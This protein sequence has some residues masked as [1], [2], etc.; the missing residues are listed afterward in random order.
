M[1]VDSS[2]EATGPVTTAQT[3][4]SDT[5]ASLEAIRAAMVAA[6]EREA[7][8]IGSLVSEA[9]DLRRQSAQLI[10]QYKAWVDKHARL[11][12]SQLSGMNFTKAS[13]PT[14]AMLRNEIFPKKPRKRSTPDDRPN[15]AERRRQ[16]DLIRTWAKN[17]GHTLNQ[18]GSIP[19]HLRDAYDQAHVTN[20][21][22]T[23]DDA[24]SDA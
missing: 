16:N 3:K 19:R 5:S 7:A 1:S 18:R 11:S 2:D 14:P 22:G 10:A 6:A 17:N 8:E 13:I 20:T 12:R 21:S 4:T 23:A 9:H 24:T 15:S